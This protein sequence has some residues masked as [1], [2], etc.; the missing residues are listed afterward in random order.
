MKIYDVL[1]Y[2]SHNELMAVSDLPV[3][4][5]ASTFMTVCTIVQG[6]IEF[7]GIFCLGTHRSLRSLRQVQNKGGSEYHTTCWTGGSF[8]GGMSGVASSIPPRLGV[9]QWVTRSDH[10]NDKDNDI[11]R[12]AI[13]ENEHSVD[14][15]LMA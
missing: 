14:G 12:S 4:I 6:S 13:N 10:E 11:S 9:L 15:I 8:A 3:N 7:I 5:S 1:N 2:R